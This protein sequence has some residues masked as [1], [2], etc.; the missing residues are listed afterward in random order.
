MGALNMDT[1][2]LPNDAPWWARW[3]VAEWQQCY[4]WFSVQALAFLAIAPEAYEM[5]PQL[6]AA[7]PPVWMH[8][9]QA[10]VAVAA[11]LGRLMQQ[12]SKTESNVIKEVKP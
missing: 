3:L 7:L 2:S 9:L 10:F 4:R 6:Q 8:H 1:N 5:A 12:K 11:I